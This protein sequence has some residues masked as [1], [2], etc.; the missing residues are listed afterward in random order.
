MALLRQL[1][2][3]KGFPLQPALLYNSSRSAARRQEDYI[4]GPY[5]KTEKERLE[6]AKKYGLLPHEYKPIP[7]DGLGKGDYPDLPHI[8]A[9]S[10]DPYYPWDYP[11]F[12]RNFNEPWHTNADIYGEDRLDPAKDWRVPKTTMI[13]MLVGMV[14][15]AF[16]L[17]Y[18]LE[19]YPV[20]RPVCRKQMPFQG[21]NH[22]S[23]ERGN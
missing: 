20:H 18:L 5:P 11:E 21:K 17:A 10:K 7:D 1:V 4:P 13:A 3:R 9:D 15:G 2:A 23:F 19:P 12:R 8:G 22:Y 6:A 16:L 14:G